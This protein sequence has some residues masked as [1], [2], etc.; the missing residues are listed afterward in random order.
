MSN[1]P[2]RL[3]LAEQLNQHRLQQAQR[4][5]TS[6]QATLWQQLPWLLHSNRPAQLGFVNGAPYRFSTAPTLTA[7]DQFT[8]SDDSCEPQLLGLYTMGSTGSVGQ[9]PD[10]DI[11]CWLIYPPSLTE[12]ALQKLEQKCQL[13]SDH[14]LQLG[15]ELHFFLL[16]PNWL[17]CGQRGQLSHDHS[18]HA[19][20]WLLLEEVY[21]SHIR[22]AGKP[23]A[24]WPHAPQDD[25]RL[26]SLGE[27]RHLPAAEVISTALW[28][29]FKGVDR[30]H[31][32]LLKILLLESYI[33]SYP[34]RQIIRD[35]LWT[36][37]RAG[38]PLAQL[39]HYQLI[40]QR[41]ERY[42][43]RIQDRRRLTLAQRCFY[44]KI[45]VPM[46]RPLSQQDDRYRYLRGL[47]GS[48]RY[49]RQL[50]Q[51][52]DN[53]QQWHAGQL[54]W[55]NDRLDQALLTSFQRMA[56]H[57][58]RMQLPKQ[59]PLGELTV[60]SRRLAATFDHRDGKVAKLN[61][62]WSQQLTE[63]KLTLV[64]SN[65]PEQ[66]QQWYLYRHAPQDK[67][68]LGQ[69]PLYHSQD[70]LQCLAWA[71]S[72]G[73]IDSHSQIYCHQQQHSR[74]SQRLTDIGRRLALWC[75]EPK[76]PR[77][78]ALSQP[79]H[80]Q[81][82][83]VVINL[84]DDPSRQLP[85]Q[86]RW[87]NANPLALGK[88]ATSLLGQL[89]LLT[90]SSWGELHCRR[91]DGLEAPLQLLK[92]LGG[93]SDNRLQ[94]QVLGYAKRFNQ[95]LCA[96]IQA[97]LSQPKT[98]L[99]WSLQLANQRFAVQWQHRQLHWCTA[100]QSLPALSNQQPQACLSAHARLGLQQVFIQ[101]YGAQ[102]TVHQSDHHNRL[103]SHTIDANTLPL[104]LDMLSL[105]RV[106]Q[107][108]GV[109]AENRHGFELPQFYRLLEGDDGKFRVE[110]WQG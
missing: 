48:W 8:D 41:I 12:T 37:L 80:Y 16:P 9:G 23:L 72:N 73:L 27:L 29:L 59:L 85:L 79:W 71:A 25:P 35:E 105:Q 100:E 108:S 57:A 6:L 5:L 93:G 58:Q 7:P 38:K 89:H 101:P 107:L 42:L 77:F 78:D 75:S 69:S 70:R 90:I 60:I 81:R 63:A 21:R 32:A 96:S 94:L 99:P 45:A 50:L 30:P 56:Q 26:L 91:Y 84:D 52:L 102:V 24:W 64:A 33:A 53:A 1:L 43:N 55:F 68:L 106:C 47:I 82:A 19:Q 67:Q 17:E 61:R 46:S 3:A 98:A 86:Q 22:L 62:L 104:A 74:L 18:G 10:S 13:I 31:K 87:P 36:G 88:P 15:L 2:D 65:Q 20:Q 66:R 14:Y 54:Q 97:L 83:L 11:D 34:D 40:Y 4:R 28:Q 49:T 76:R 39:D 109:A 44:L 95:A 110:D 103:H 92:Q 51:H